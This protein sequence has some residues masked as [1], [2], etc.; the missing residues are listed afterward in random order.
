MLPRCFAKKKRSADRRRA[1]D[2]AARAAAACVRDGAVREA[3]RLRRRRH[4]AGRGA[5]FFFPYTSVS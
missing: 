3:V 1:A 5:V 2:R 4:A